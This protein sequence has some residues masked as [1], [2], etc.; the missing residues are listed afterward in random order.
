[1]RTSS[2]LSRSRGYKKGTETLPRSLSIMRAVFLKKG[3][4][5]SSG[6]TM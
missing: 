1:M 6:N 5:L 4:S 2:S 3:P